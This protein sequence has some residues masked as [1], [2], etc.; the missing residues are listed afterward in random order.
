MCF[1]PV[2]NG[3]NIVVGR[4]RVAAVLSWRP[5]VGLERWALL[6]GWAVGQ[7]V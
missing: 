5:C 1:I 4:L 6:L 2:M 3:R 7:A